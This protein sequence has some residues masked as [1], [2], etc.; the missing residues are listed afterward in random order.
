MQLFIPKRYKQVRQPMRGG[1]SRVYICEDS[2][3]KRRVVVKFVNSPVDEGRLLDEILA[4]QN[5]KSKHVVQIYDVF[6]DPNLP[7]Y[8]IV[9]EY[10]DGPNPSISPDGPDP[11]RRFISLLYQIATGL[12][13]LHGQGI[14]H[15]DIKLDNIKVDES[16]L[17]KIYDFGLARFLG[18]NNETQGFVGTLGY[19]A[20]EL[21][22][23]DKV[24]FTEAI[25]VYSFG[26]LAWH[27]SGESLPATLSPIRRGDVPSFRA[28][29]VGIPPSIC[30]LLDASL[31]IDPANRPA[32]RDLQLALEDNL[33]VGKHK[34]LLVAPNA[35][36]TIDITRPFVRINLGTSPGADR[37]SI[38]ISYTGHHFEVVE[39]VG[40]VKVNNRSILPGEVMPKSCVITLGAGSDRKAFATFDISNPE[41]VV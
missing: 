33:L 8:G 17:A 9:L 39:T 23:D 3:L 4:L 2:L 13:D 24:D 15:R 6:Y 19:A 7:G 25:D 10:V 31:S 32:I 27:L 38:G 12:S 40:D 36:Q 18:I 14:I 16:G 22:R 21:L 35:V 41:V 11:A 34:G 26:V 20:P 5:V 29:P 28:L 30:K 37:W 1:M